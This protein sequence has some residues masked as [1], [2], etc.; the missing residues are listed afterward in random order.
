[1][2][3]PFFNKGES[4][5]RVHE[6][7]KLQISPEDRIYIVDDYSP[8]GV[9]DLDCP[10]TRIIRPPHKLTPHLY[11]LNTLRNLGVKE[12]RHDC[13]VVLDPDCLPNPTF[14]ASARLLFDPSILYAGRIDRRRRDDRPSLD[15][16]L[17]DQGSCWIDIGRGEGNGEKVH[18]GCMMFS[19]SRAALI[20]WFDTDFDGAWGYEEHEFAS[21]CFNSG[22]RLYYVVEL[23]V[24]H[25]WHEPIKPGTRNNGDMLQKKVSMN[26]EHL[27]ITTSYKPGFGISV[28]APSNPNLLSWH[29][30]AVF[31]NVIPIKVRLCVNGDNSPEMKRALLPWEGRWAVEI[32]MQEKTSV[33]KIHDDAVN[34]AKNKGYKHLINLDDAGIYQNG[35][36][37]IVEMMRNHNAEYSILK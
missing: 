25:L 19:K 30:R 15:P 23:L 7:L 1:M 6:E 31:R 22:M 17:T 8:D 32:V 10:C 36:I 4:L 21:R 3:I 16:R 26:R 34:W 13:I 37:D 14:L 35:V 24:T 27:D 11:R 28:V 2:V 18:G 20:D 9:P 29:L 5:K 12:A 33:E